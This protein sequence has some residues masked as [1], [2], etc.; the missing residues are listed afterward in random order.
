MANIAIETTSRIDR[1]GEDEVIELCSRLFE[2]FDPMYVRSRLPH[3]TGPAITRARSIDGDLIG[4]KLGYRLGS[5]LFYSWLG[6]VHPEYRKQG[7]AQ[8][9]LSDQHQWA[10]EH[11]Y[12]RIETRTRAS[13]SPMIVLNLKSGFE[14]VGFELNAEQIGVVI[15]RKTL[16]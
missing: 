16:Q 3:I 1:A 15:Q 6:G 7:I 5:T 10:A 9:L 12:S 14:I 11:G 4:F 8:Q 13:N 2:T